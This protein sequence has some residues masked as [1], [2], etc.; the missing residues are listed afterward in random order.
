VYPYAAPRESFVW[1]SIYPAAQNMV[2]AARS[3]GLGTVFTTFHGVAEPAI[4]EV[5]HIPDDVLIGCLIPM[6]WPLRQ[7]GPVNRVPVDQ[8]IHE[9]RWRGDLRSVPPTM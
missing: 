9:D 5:L 2:V 7:F 1:S 8:V 4:R 3:L 6:G